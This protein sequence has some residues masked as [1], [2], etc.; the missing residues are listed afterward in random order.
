MAFARSVGFGKWRGALFSLLV[1]LPESTGNLA[2]WIPAASDVLSQCR[3]FDKASLRIKRD[4]RPNV[5]SELSF[6]DV[7]HHPGTGE[8]ADRVVRGTI[9]SAKGRSLDAVFLALK[10]RGAASRQYPNLLGSDMLDEEELRL[11]YVAVTRARKA[12]ALA[13]PSRHVESWRQFLFG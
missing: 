10:T 5:Y 2:D 4:R 3:L 7:F 13:V 11:V 6:R 9:H 12:L 8:Q 1:A